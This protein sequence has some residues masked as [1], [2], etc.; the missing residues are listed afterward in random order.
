M[1]PAY[2]VSC[3]EKKPKICRTKL[4]AYNYA[5]LYESLDYTDVRITEAASQKSSGKDVMLGDRPILECG[6]LDVVIDDLKRSRGILRQDIGRRKYIEQHLASAPAPLTAAETY[7]GAD[8]KTFTAEQVIVPVLT[9]L[10]YTDG[11]LSKRAGP[12]MLLKLRGATVAIVLEPLDTASFEDDSLR[13]L[14][15]ISDDA[16]DKKCFAGIFTDGAR[17]LLAVKVDGRPVSS[18]LIDIRNLL[19]TMFAKDIE[20]SQYQRYAGLWKFFTEMF[21]SDTLIPSART[22]EDRFRKQ[23][24]VQVGSD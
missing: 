24:A 18:G 1:S 19:R 17:W 5:K 23:L 12:D 11:N 6:A 15:H 22:I 8:P 2:K 10:G 9:C 13:V 21:S 20:E 7:N 14:E 4:Q 16:E 3:N